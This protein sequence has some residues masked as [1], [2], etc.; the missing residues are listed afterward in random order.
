M[1]DGLSGC[2]VHP[3]EEQTLPYSMFFSAR[4]KIEVQDQ[5]IG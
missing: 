3:Q 5:E 2:T 4:L 1:Y